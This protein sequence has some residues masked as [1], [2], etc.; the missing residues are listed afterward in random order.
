M[1]IRLVALP[2]AVL[3]LDRITKLWAVQALCQAPLSLYGEYISCMLT[4]NRGISWSLLSFKDT[5]GFALVTLLI[6]GMLITL[7][8]YTAQRAQRGAFISG[9]LLVLSGGLSNVYDRIMHGG[10]IDFILLQ[11][12]DWSFPVF[13]IADVAIV[14]G[15]LIMMYDAARS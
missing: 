11:Y 9:E 5:F 2:I 7:T 14:F 13:N 3:I 6:V 12:G 1:N 4:Y 15:I 8:V 10:V